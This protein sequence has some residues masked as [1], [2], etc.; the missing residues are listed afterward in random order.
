[1]PATMMRS[2][3]CIGPFHGVAKARRWERSRALSGGSGSKR[4][5]S[6][7][8]G[9]SSEGGSRLHCDHHRAVRRALF[10][11]GPPRKRPAAH[12][13][14][15]REWSWHDVMRAGVSGADLCVGTWRPGT[16]GNKGRSGAVTLARAALP[17]Q[18]QPQK[19]RPP[20][21][22]SPDLARATTTRGFVATPERS[23][24]SHWR[25]TRLI[26]RDGTPETARTGPGSRGGTALTHGEDRENRQRT[27]WRSRA[28]RSALSGALGLARPMGGNH[29]GRR[30]SRPAAVPRS[31]IHESEDGDGDGRCP[32]WPGS[33]G[34]RDRR[35]VG[36]APLPDRPGHARGRVRAHHRRPRSRGPRGGRSPRGRH[37]AP[38]GATCDRRRAASDSARGVRARVENERR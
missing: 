17:V 36:P 5:S 32:L 23:G 19:H 24:R 27:A 3:R 18:E 13:A 38:A 33:R 14:T 15:G 37:R 6:F 28:M 31:G 26:A 34:R 35:V 30:A 21:N 4:G 7:T 16:A 9:R 1:M 20:P 11:A 29:G 25:R 22:L 12:T 8:A 2:A 10:C